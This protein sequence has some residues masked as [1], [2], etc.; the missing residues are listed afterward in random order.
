MGMVQERKS[1]LSEKRTKSGEANQSSSEAVEKEG[2]ETK[3]LTHL[4]YHTDLTLEFPSLI[5]FPGLT[6]R[7]V[8]CCF[9]RKYLERKRRVE[10]QPERALTAELQTK[11]GI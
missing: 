9:V 3:R 7:G 6:G 5:V 10:L 1:E 2:A 8:D 4:N 11:R